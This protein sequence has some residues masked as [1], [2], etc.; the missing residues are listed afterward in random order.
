MRQAIFL[1][2]A[3]FVILAASVRATDLP[4]KKVTVLA[5]ENTFELT[6]ALVD[7][8]ELLVPAKNVAAITGFELKPQGL[9]AA[10][11][12]IPIPKDGGW[13]L[14]Q[15][16]VTY[17]NLTRFAAKVDQVFAVDPE[18]NVWSF[19]AVP[20]KPTL[21][22]VAGEAPDFALPDRNGKIV[23]LSD[24]RGKKVFLLTWASWCGCRFDLAEWQKIYEELKGKNFEIV[25]AAQDTCGL[26]AAGT[27]YDKA[28]VTY[29]ALVDAKHTVS[30]LYQM[31]NVPTGVWIDETGKIVRPGEVSYAKR[32]KVLGQTIG[33]DRY[34]LGLR[35]WVEKGPQ[36]AYLAS[37]ERLQRQLAIRDS[38][39]RLADAHFKIGA[40]F[41]EASKRDL[42]TKHWQQAQE[43]NPDSWNYHRQDWSFD[44]GKEM[45]NFLKKVGKLAGKPYYDPAE[46]PQT[47]PVVD[48]ASAAP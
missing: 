24:F 31:V 40:Y 16:G 44:K 36:S 17:L 33:D 11:V 28:K 22:L 14:E 35:D 47:K 6:D 15:G 32:Q 19:T 29:T 38:R 46:F 1:S 13:L 41:S 23:R 18:Q 10:D 37:P 3:A 8:Q 26:A 20:E 12:C 5:R 42:A 30:S 21:P 39:L 7:G 9:C 27:W 48:P 34:A 2:I 43:L 25:A 4:P 45:G